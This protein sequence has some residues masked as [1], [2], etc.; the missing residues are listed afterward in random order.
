M[1]IVKWQVVL[2]AQQ[3]HS[4]KTCLLDTARR[5]MERV[6]GIAPSSRPW[7]GRI[8]LLNQTRKTG[9]P[10]RTLTSN[11]T[12]RKRPLC[13]LSYEARFQEFAEGWLASTKHLRLTC[14]IDF[15]SWG[16]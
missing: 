14:P 11:L 6:N 9:V 3:R 8:L 1:T 2:C 7:H 12:L 15:R 13:A 16:S 10:G 5:K 4:R